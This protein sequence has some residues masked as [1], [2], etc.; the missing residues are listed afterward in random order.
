MGNIGTDFEFE[1]AEE[2]GLQRVPGS[3]NKWANKLDVKGK[4]TRWSLKATGKSG[5]RVGAAMLAEALHVTE[6]I[7]GTGETPVWAVRV[8]E[9]DF[10]IMRLD[11]WVKLVRDEGFSIK[12]TKTEEKRRRASTP[13]LLRGD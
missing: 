4:G 2:L 8:K 13:Q 3:G 11:D 6:G 10:V 7:G 9:G 1:L 5:F 12:P